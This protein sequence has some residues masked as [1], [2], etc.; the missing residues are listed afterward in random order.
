MGGLFFPVL[1]QHIEEVLHIVWQGGFEGDDFVGCGVLEGN[2]PCVEG[3]AGDN[4]S[5]DGGGGVF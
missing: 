2:R 5:F 4:G 1:S 3:A